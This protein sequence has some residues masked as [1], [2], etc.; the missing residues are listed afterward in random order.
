MTIVHL[1]GLR[2]FH[3]PPSTGVA[4][5]VVA[6]VRRRSCCFH[7]DGFQDE[8]NDDNKNNYNVCLCVSVCVRNPI[9]RITRQE[10]GVFPF[11]R[12]SRPHPPSPGE[13]GTRFS[14]PFKENQ[15]QKILWRVF[16]IIP[17]SLG[18]VGRWFWLPSAPISHHPPFGFWTN[19]LSHRPNLC[20]MVLQALL[21]KPIAREYTFHR[22]WEL[23]VKLY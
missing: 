5:V 11:K 8:S 10:V 18:D 13:M 3:L 19:N 20:D 1:G 17:F 4:V 16:S 21:W 9:D 23:F 22:M 7:R 12:I 15:Q 14:L 2:T 6:V